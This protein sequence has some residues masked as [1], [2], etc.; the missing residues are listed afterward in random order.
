MAKIKIVDSE[1]LDLAPDRY[2]MIQPI[3]SREGFRMMEEFV[4][5]L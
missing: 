5:S 3:S 4:E 1:L 2:L